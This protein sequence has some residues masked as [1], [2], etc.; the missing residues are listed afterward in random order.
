MD[1]ENI[2]HDSHQNLWLDSHPIA[3]LHRKG[4]SLYMQQ[5]TYTYLRLDELQFW[6][7]HL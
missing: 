2:S 5:N 6:F 4:L 7:E 1:K 3:W